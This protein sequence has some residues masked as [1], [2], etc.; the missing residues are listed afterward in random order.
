MLVMT[1]SW[2]WTVACEKV[3]PFVI[4]DFENNLI[5]PSSSGDHGPERNYKPRSLGNDSSIFTQIVVQ[6]KKCHF[7]LWQRRDYSNIFKKW[8]C[9]AIAE[10]TAWRNHLNPS[11]VLFNVTSLSS[12]KGWKRNLGIP[13]LHRVH[14][15][16]S[17]VPEEHHTRHVCRCDESSLITL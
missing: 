4:Y 15:L 7:S 14:G 1:K 17:P 12:I 5:C 6:S 16:C 13:R 9:P 10:Q 11:W 3:S 2:W 8:S